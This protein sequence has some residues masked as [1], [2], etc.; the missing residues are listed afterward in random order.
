MHA[1]VVVA[2]IAIGSMVAAPASSQ[3]LSGTDGANALTTNYGVSIKLDTLPAQLRCPKGAKLTSG[4]RFEVLCI[5]PTTGIG[6]TFLWRQPSLD[7]QV[8][9]QW[10]IDNARGKYA[11]ANSPTRIMEAGAPT[12]QA[13]ALPNIAGGTLT[14]CGV[15]VGGG[16]DTTFAMA[17]FPISGGNA[18]M[19]ITVRSAG[20]FTTRDMVVSQMQSILSGLSIVPVP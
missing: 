15:T 12:C 2:A 16:W 13:A 20:G 7:D 8:I 10:V 4:K 9:E 14:T 6:V 11:D 3:S 1:A 17:T 19:T 5:A 18:K